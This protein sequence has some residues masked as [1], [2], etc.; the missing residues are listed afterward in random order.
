MTYTFKLRQGV[1]FQNGKPMTSADVAASF[2]RY[3]KVGLERSML[4]NVDHWEATDPDTFVIH[5][6]KAQPT[7]RTLLSPFSVPIVIIPSEDKDAPAMQLNKV[8]GTGPTS[9]CSSCRAAS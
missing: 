2:D 8:V 9:L 7:F 3:A 6:K 1:H 5:M 4:A